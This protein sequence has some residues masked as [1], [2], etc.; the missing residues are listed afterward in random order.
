VVGDDR[1]QVR[2]L[3]ADADDRHLHAGMPASD[4]LQRI[5]D[6]CAVAARRAQEGEHERPALG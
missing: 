3:A 2:E 6:V 1:A 5:E 4:L